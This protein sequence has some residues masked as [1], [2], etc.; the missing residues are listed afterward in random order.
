MFKYLIKYRFINGYFFLS[1]LFSIQ[2]LFYPLLGTK[3]FLYYFF[4]YQTLFLNLKKNVAI[5]LL[6]IKITQVDICKILL[7]NNILYIIEFN[8]WY[9]TGRIILYFVYKLNINEELLFLIIFNTIL[10]ASITIGT[11]ISSSDLATI[12]NPVLFNIA[13]FFLF[14]IFLAIFISILSVLMFFFKNAVFYMII[15]IITII[16][17]Y[18]IIVNIKL[19]YVRNQEYL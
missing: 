11:K 17:W 9:L 2:I 8:L 14:N 3:V 16:I 18:Q 5:P 10:I 13:R 12:N 19:V 6:L 15:L 4:L 1:F 7:Y